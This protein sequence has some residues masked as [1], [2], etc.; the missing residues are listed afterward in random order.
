MIGRLLFSE[1]ESLLE[2]EWRLK[3]SKMQ[4]LGLGE[5]FTAP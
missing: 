1:H 5:A 2:Q 3:L 4:A